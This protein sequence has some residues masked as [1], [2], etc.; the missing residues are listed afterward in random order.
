MKTHLFLTSA[1]LFATM[2]ST[3]ASARAPRDEQSPENTRPILDELV[4]LH[5]VRHI[6][7]GMTRAQALTSMRGRPDETM[8]A[9][10]WIY[11][12]FQGNKRPASMERAAMLIFFT[13]DRVSDI[14]YSEERL[15]RQTLG[16]LRRAPVNAAVAAQ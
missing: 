14:R 9:D 12:N 10:V 1:L 6:K 8:T 4:P 16:Q 2:S 15:V 11:W 13:A 3:P 5:E 7:R